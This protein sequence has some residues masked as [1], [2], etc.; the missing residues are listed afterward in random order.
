MIGGLIIDAGEIKAVCLAEVVVGVDGSSA[1]SLAANI[2]E[3]LDT[4]I[5][6]RQQLKQQLIGRCLELLFPAC[7][8]RAP[9]PQAG[10]CLCWLSLLA[11]HRIPAPST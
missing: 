10:C 5:S 9:V 11:P 3:A 4:Y 6:D 1:E 8:C 7:T 2:L